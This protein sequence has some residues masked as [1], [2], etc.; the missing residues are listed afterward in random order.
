MTFK[1]GRSA[2]PVYWWGGGAPAVRTATDVPQVTS[3]RYGLL[4]RPGL[5]MDRRQDD[6]VY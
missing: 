2:E 1:P 3:N 5:S 6:I 4:K